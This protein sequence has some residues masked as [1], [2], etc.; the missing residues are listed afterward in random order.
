MIIQR[1]F[2]RKKTELGESSKGRGKSIRLSHPLGYFDYKDAK[3]AATE[4]A[5]EGNSEAEIIERSGKAAKKTGHRTGA[6]EGAANTAAV[7]GGLEGA[8]RWLAKDSHPSIEKL[9]NKV[10]KAIEKAGESF[11]KDGAKPKTISGKLLKKTG[12]WFGKKLGNAVGDNLN[13]EI[14]MRGSKFAKGKGGK[15]I[16]LGGTALAGLH[17]LGHAVSAGSKSEHGAYQ[18]TLDRIKKG[19]EKK[20][21]EKKVGKVMEAVPDKL[22]EEEAKAII[23]KL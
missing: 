7:Y 13:S 10:A 15:A 12:T 19:K 16:V 3:K 9:G 23:K 21:L 2:S 4:A 8:R 6:V 11:S 18:N 20:A 17:G 22:T 5:K 14:V 1:T